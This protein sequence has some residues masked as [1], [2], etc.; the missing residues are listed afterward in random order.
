MRLNLGC[1][2]HKLAGW[3]N[4]D[5]ADA[6][7]NSDLRA[8]P[9]VW[10]ND[11]ANAILASHILEHFTR[12]D[13]LEFLRECH[14]ILKDGAPLYVAVP[15]MDKFIDCQLSGDF[16]PLGGYGWTSL[17]SLLGGGDSEPRP[18]WRHQYMYSWRSLESAMIE[19]GFAPVR[20]D[21]R[22]FDNPAYNAISLYAVGEAVK[23]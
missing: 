9:W 5:L 18:E 16:S 7:L 13:G 21:A 20:T 11:T 4:V 1:G 22:E 19:A 6:D 12:A 2:P 10:A 15:D 17:D 14:R 3:V 8:R 23:L